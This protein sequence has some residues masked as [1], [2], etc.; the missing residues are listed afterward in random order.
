VALTI[1]YTAAFVVIYPLEEYVNAPQK[2]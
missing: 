1:D 2:N